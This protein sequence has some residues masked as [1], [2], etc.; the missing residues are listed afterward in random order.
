VGAL[1]EALDVLQRLFAPFLP[2]VT[3]EVWSWWREGSI[4]RS[5]WPEADDLGA[6]GDPLVVTVAAE[7]LTAI[8]KEKALAK[9]SL[10]APVERVTVVDAPERLSA[11]REAVEDVREAGSVAELDLVEGEESS[12][13]VVL[14]P[15]DAA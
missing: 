13:D 2:Y 6:G 15:P 8:R 1:R 7:V 4:H 5:S 9:V 12:I 3:E 10:R 14:A 11:L